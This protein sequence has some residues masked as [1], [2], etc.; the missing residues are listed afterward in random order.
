MTG[1]LPSPT[2]GSLA[3]LAGLEAGDPHAL[4][5]VVLAHAV[6]LGYGGVPV[7]WMGDEVGLLNDPTWD[8]EPEHADDNRWVHRPRMPWVEGEHRPPDPHGLLPR[9]EHLVAVRAATPHLQAA[10][11]AQVLADAPDGVLAVLRRPPPGPFLGLHN[12]TPSPRSV[13]RWLLERA[14]LPA[15][16]HDR[17]APEA[18]LPADGDVPLAA[19]QVR[20]LTA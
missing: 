15:A 11:P 18:D 16:A 17:L 13:P 5:R 12:M 3:S 1:P 20:W 2:E 6:V 14:G 19:Y 9:L 7:I 8:A 4:D 10:T